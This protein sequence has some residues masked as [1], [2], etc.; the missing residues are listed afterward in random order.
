M[1]SCTDLFSF[2]EMNHVSL[3][4]TTAPPITTT[5]AD[6][7]K[8]DCVDERPSLRRDGHQATPPNDAQVVTS[9]DDVIGNKHETTSSPLNVTLESQDTTDTSA[10]V[11]SS[12]D[13]LLGELAAGEV[14][15]EPTG[16]DELG[17]GGEGGK[18]REE[19]KAEE[20]RK[21]DAKR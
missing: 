10:D 7:T 4:T 18:E 11:D 21:R 1:K 19:E 9:V 15:V 12:Y 6:V 20:R 8:M 16:G 2:N 5:S 13:S 14:V 3:V 17:G